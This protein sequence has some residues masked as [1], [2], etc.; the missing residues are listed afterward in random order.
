M[1][2]PLVAKIQTP[3]ASARL[4]G[5]FE[6]DEPEAVADLILCTRCV[7]V[8]H[9]IKQSEQPFLRGFSNQLSLLVLS[10]HVWFSGLTVISL[11]GRG[12]GE[13]GGAYTAADPISRG[14]RLLW[15]SLS[16]PP[17][18]ILTILTNCTMHPRLN[19]Y[20]NTVV[21][22]LTRLSGLILCH[23]ITCTHAS[24]N[25]VTFFMKH[26]KNTDKNPISIS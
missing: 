5:T 25:Q 4:I 11:S 22:P 19:C 14:D 2:A 10:R 26:L 18:L 21:F 1:N 24:T 16:W 9:T 20:L 13:V 23:V 17:V 6:N 3:G 8:K 12:V 7:T 15:S